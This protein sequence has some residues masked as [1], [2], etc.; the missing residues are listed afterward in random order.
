MPTMASFQL[1]VKRATKV[2]T[3]TAAL[4]ITRARV[5]LITELTPEISVLK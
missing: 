5:L 2:V 1:M 3:M 4:L